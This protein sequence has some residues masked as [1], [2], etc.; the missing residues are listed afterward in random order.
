MS[1]KLTVVFFIVI[2]FEI[3]MLLVILPWLG[4][5][6]WTENYLL[7]AAVDKL[8]YNWLATVMKSGYLRG[9]VTGLGLLN[10]MLGIWEI[11]NFNKTVRRFQSEWQGKELDNESLASARL[12]DHRPEADA[13]P[14]ESR[15]TERAD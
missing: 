1:A 14:Q 2:C 6:P 7:I 11:V 15:S 13:S 10:I 9:A 5:P 8:Q 3:G 12:P 4:F